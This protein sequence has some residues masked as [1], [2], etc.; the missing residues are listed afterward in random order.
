MNDTDILSAVD[1]LKRNG[2]KIRTENMIGVPGE[3]WQTAMQTL[4]LNAVCKPEIAWASLYQPYPGTDLGD[5]CKEVGLYDG[6][7]NDISDSFF[8]TYKLKSEYGAEFEKLQKLFSLAVEK[9]WVRKSLPLL[10][11]LPFGYMKTYKK[12]KNSL[13]KN[14]YKV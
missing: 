13:Y 14:L 10:T 6:D 11:K 4:K 1:I 12:T 2:I 7:L 8:D 5:Y 3:T 9:S